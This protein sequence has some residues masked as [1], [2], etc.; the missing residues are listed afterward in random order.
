MIFIHL[1]FWLFI[2]LL[3][4][5]LIKYHE[6]I[7]AII[8]FFGALFLEKLHLTYV[9]FNISTYH[10]FLNYFY[11]LLKSNFLIIIINLFITIS[12]LSTLMKMI[13]KWIKIGVFIVILYWLGS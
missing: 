4:Y 13:K 11:W 12:I 5:I 7:N 3:I 1:I 8:I 9:L 10:V 6:Y 2:I